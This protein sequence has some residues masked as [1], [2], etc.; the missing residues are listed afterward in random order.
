MLQNHT[1]TVPK[2]EAAEID[3][4]NK[5][6]HSADA[7]LV[8]AGAGLSVSAGF[9]YSGERFNRYFRDFQEKYGVQDM[10]TGGFFPYSTPE[11]YWAYWSRYIW[12]N[13]YLDAPNPVYQDLLR[14]VGDHDY[15][16]LT[17]NVDHCFHKAGF[18]KNRLFYTQG[19]YGLFQC[20]EPCCQETWDNKAAVRQMIA[21]QE[22]MRIPATQVPRCPRCGKLATMNLRFDDKF[23]QD[24]GWHRAAEQYYDFLRRH[25]TMRILF[26][27]LGVGYNTPG[28]IKYPFW[29]MTARNPKGIYACINN[30]QISCPQEIAKQSICV[31][32]DIGTVLKELV[33]LKE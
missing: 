29:Q 4:L 17:T 10:Y 6:L 24:E 3:R 33:L 26:L 32:M 27:E 5:A 20:S 16:I 7:V 23:V 28:I 9:S 13:R 11:E 21:L 19:D 14:L 8:G 22:D 2:S 1:K 30:G 12:V 18:H 25:Q 15:F 31:D